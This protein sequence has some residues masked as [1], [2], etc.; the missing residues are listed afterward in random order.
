MGGKPH[1]CHIYHIWYMWRKN[2]HVEK[3]QIFMHDRCVEIWNFS[4]C[5]EFKKILHIAN[6]EKSQI[7]PH[8]TCVMWRMSSQMYNLCCIVVKSVLSRFTLFCCKISIVAI[9]ALLYGENFNQKLHMWRKYDKY[10]VW[11]GGG[12]SSMT[13]TTKCHQFH[14][15]NISRMDGWMDHFAGLICLVLIIHKGC[16]DMTSLI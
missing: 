2:C 6:V 10:E 3:F 4:A 12:I 5:E 11:W 15:L 16:V 8:L 14:V 1:I 13:K 7:S 9:Y